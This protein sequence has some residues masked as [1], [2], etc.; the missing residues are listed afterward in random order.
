MHIDPPHA[1]HIGVM[2]ALTR[3]GV[4]TELLQTEVLHP[5]HS[6]SWDIIT[7]LT[8][9]AE[10]LDR[11]CGIKRWQASSYYIQR[12]LR[13][14]LPNRNV[15]N[16]SAKL[17]SGKA[18][19]RVDAKRLRLFPHIDVQKE[20]VFN[21]MCDHANLSRRYKDS[22]EPVPYNVR[23]L[24][25]NLVLG[26]AVNHGMFGR[27][28]EWK[29]AEREREYV[30]KQLKDDANFL[31]CVYYKTASTYGDL[32]K[33]LLPGTKEALRAYDAIPRADSGI[34]WFFVPARTGSKLKVGSEVE[35]LPLEEMR[36]SKV[37]CVS[38]SNCLTRFAKTHWVGHHP[39]GV[40]LNRMWHS[41]IKK[42]QGTDE[43]FKALCKIAKHA[44]QTGKAVYCPT[45]QRKTRRQGSNC[46]SSCSKNQ[47]LGQV[48]N[49]LLFG[50]TCWTVF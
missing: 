32:G 29:I 10:Y 42:M 11:Q 43:A 7:A 9:Y 38:V 49:K 1:D 20:F 6:W 3:D 17:D 26:I 28:G 16:A 2:V 46:T 34:P 19:N 22:Q 5:R 25:N 27:D 13:D 12:L 47:S 44:T 35:Q 37:G 14:V 36:S 15:L 39:P 21:A 40:N 18:K 24:A 45:D 33:M 30:R 23:S 8:Q 50:I 31:E 41:A 4:M 48:S